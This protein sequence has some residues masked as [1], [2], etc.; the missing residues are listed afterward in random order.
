[1]REIKVTTT[2][3]PEV[4]IFEDG[5]GEWRWRLKAA[6]GEITAQSE[7]YTNKADAMR[8]FRAHARNVLVVVMSILDWPTTVNFKIIQRD[9]KVSR[10]EEG[11]TQ[12]A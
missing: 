12:D 7:G 8:G 4:E 10:A 5:A 11:G 1:M 3:S 2:V 6:N 9:E